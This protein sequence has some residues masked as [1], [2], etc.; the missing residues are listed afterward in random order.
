MYTTVADIEAYFGTTFTVDTSPTMSAIEEW[1]AQGSA[2]ID[3]F[4]LK[5]YILPITEASDL[6]VLKVIANTYVIPTV[7]ECLGKTTALQ[8]SNGTVVQKDVD[9]REFMGYLKSLACGD[10]VLQSSQ[11]LNN[12]FDYA[13]NECYCS[14]ECY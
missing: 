3:S 6:L 1:I 2:M 4:L 11:Q 12:E 13:E 7:K 8:L 5:K 9:R 10:L 14:N